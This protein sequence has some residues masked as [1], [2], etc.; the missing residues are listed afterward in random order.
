M[1]MSE[2]RWQDKAALEVQDSFRVLFLGVA[3]SLSSGRQNQMQAPPPKPSS[4][5]TRSEAL[6]VYHN[7]QRLQL[8]DS[9]RSRRGDK[10]AEFELLDSDGEGMSEETL[11]PRPT[12][13]AEDPLKPIS[14][15]GLLSWTEE[16]Q[17]WGIDAK[18]R[19]AAAALFRG[20]KIWRKHRASS[21]QRREGVSL[22]LLLQLIWPSLSCLQIS[23][24]LTQLGHEEIVKLRYPTPRL[25]SSDERR[26]L[27]RIFDVFAKG[28]DFCTGSDLAGGHA[29][30]VQTRLL[31]LVDAATVHA[32][33]GEANITLDRFLEYMT[34][35]GVR[36][37]EGV[38]RVPLND[39]TRIALESRELL[40]FSGWLSQ[41]LSQDDP[42]RR[43]V[44]AFE[45]EVLRWR[46]TDSLM[47]GG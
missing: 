43:L 25:I 27:E 1:K 41:D 39:G 8:Q 13:L 22:A 34:E 45:A 21:D 11:S 24:V 33:M 19:A 46:D 32:V 47:N 16:E 7:F 28:A 20:L 38:T 23:E 44:E 26:Q 5:P 35:D 12:S 29:P 10:V 30:D 6:K 42:Q 2:A 37:H 14:W 31:T 18:T 9:K 4:Y 15:G 40:A 36:G 17:D 3:S